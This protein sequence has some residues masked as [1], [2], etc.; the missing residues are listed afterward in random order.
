[1]PKKQSS[2]KKPPK[3]EMGYISPFRARQKK[4]LAERGETEEALKS[5]YMG[6]QG[7]RKKKLDEIKRAEEFNKAFKRDAPSIKEFIRLTR[8]R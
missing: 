5:S 4:L 2:N 7:E 1:M 8:K 6:P 3:D